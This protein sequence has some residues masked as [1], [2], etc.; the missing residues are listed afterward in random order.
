MCL[1]KWILYRYVS[2]VVTSV[3]EET[4]HT[5]DATKE[6]C[7][8]QKEVQNIWLWQTNTW[9]I[10]K[11]LF[12]IKLIRNSFNIY[13]SLICK[14]HIKYSILELSWKLIGNIIP[15]TN[16]TTTQSYFVTYGNLTKCPFK[17]MK[18]ESIYVTLSMHTVKTYIWY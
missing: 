2:Q 14:L 6:V 16:M 4:R 17:Y 10:M 18:G 9:F 13:H 1:H 11:I 7:L 3:Q 12:C 15:G 8:L 5:S